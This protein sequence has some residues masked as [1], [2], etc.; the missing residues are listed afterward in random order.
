MFKH[1]FPS[2]LLT[3]P[4]PEPFS[5]LEFN[6]GLIFFPP[7]C[8]YEGW[9]LGMAVAERKQ[10]DASGWFFSAACC[11]ACAASQPLTVPLLRRLRTPAHPQGQ[12]SC[13]SLHWGCKLHLEISLV[14]WQRDSILRWFEGLDSA[15]LIPRAAQTP[16]HLTGRQLRDPPGSR[17]VARAGRA[18]TGLRQ[19]HRRTKGQK[20]K[21]DFQSQ[22]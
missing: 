12:L 21:D 10:R 20:L 17:K 11:G 4:C 8:D 9:K 6:K 5:N 2:A 16:P 15:S 22:K 3:P 19:R 1:L 18:S 14:R 7:L 13:I